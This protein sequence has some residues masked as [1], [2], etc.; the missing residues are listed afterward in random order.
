MNSPEYKNTLDYLFGLQMVGI[1]LGLDN[2]RHLLDLLGNPQESFPS[3]HIAGTN[4]KGS[5]ASFLASI[6]TESGYKVGL[7][8]SPHL[9]DFSE[10]IRVNGTAIPE[11]YIVTFTQ[12]IRPEIDAGKMTFFEATTAMAF[13]YFSDSAV[14]IA[15]VETGLGGRLDATNVI[16]PV[17]SIITSIDIEHSEFLGSTIEEIASEKGGIIKAETDLVTAVQQP[18]ALSVLQD[19]CTKQMAKLHQIPVAVATDQYQDVDS[20]TASLQFR[21][22]RQDFVLEL[23]GAY[24]MQN[25]Q[26]AVTAVELLSEKCAMSISSDALSRGLRSVRSNTGIAGRL[27][28]ISSD[29][30]IV[31][32]VAHNPAAVIALI[33]NWLKLRDAETTSIVIGFMG[34]KDIA[35]IFD[36]LSKF[37]WKA[38]YL[39]QAA[40]VSSMPVQEL[41]AYANSAGIQA[42]SS[43]SPVDAVKAMYST[44]GQNESILIFGS[45][46]VVGEYLAAIKEP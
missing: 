43:M 17:L 7:Y 15:I 26:L 25:A 41:I 11:D 34:N 13:Q 18:E 23:I 19:I 36:L 33:E 46:Y 40:A 30:E 39:V 3:V 21:G 31:V 22:S 12:R 1:K 16:Q 28:R 42:S 24:Q 20:M 14:D 2:I 27:L 35:A 32:D 44:A 9:I 5:T 38:V 29:P 10:R 45:H 4:G 8:T 37:P 6:L